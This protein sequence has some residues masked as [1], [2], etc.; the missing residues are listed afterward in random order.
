MSFV[1]F[2]TRKINYYLTKKS[3]V[4][5]KIESVFLCFHLWHIIKVLFELAEVYFE[6]F[7]SFFRTGLIC[8]LSLS[9]HPF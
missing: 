7:S 4:F 1:F 9:L 3:Y 8:C 6:V 5:S 2:E